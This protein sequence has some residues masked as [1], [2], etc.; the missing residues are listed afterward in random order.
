MKQACDDNYMQ[1]FDAPEV[2]HTQGSPNKGVTDRRYAVMKNVTHTVL[3]FEHNVGLM[4]GHQRNP[5]CGLT[6]IH[7]TRVVAPAQLHRTDQYNQQRFPQ[8]SVHP[9]SKSN[10][11]TTHL[12]Q[13]AQQQELVYCHQQP[14]QSIFT[15]GCQLKIRTKKHT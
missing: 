12:Q 5:Q 13:T 7:S 15:A 11:V 6:A 10:Q 4:Y 9:L 14:Q 8:L 1:C 3:S 2:V